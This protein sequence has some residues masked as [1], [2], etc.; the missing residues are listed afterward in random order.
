MA[1]GHAPSL[2]GIHTVA[3]TGAQ[4]AADPQ[5]ARALL[6]EACREAATRFDAQAVILG[7]AGL[8][9]MAADIAAERAG[10]ADRQRERRRRMG[11]RGDPIRLRRAG[12]Q[13]LRRGLAERL[14]GARGAGLTRPPPA[15]T[16]VPTDNAVVRDRATMAG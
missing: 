8:A 1:L 14:V 12:A 16:G 9:G 13:G 15:T 10:A 5:G 7:G 11:A 3:P 2:A 4:L 6:A